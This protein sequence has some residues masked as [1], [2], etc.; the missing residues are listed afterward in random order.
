MHTATKQ[1]GS[2]R[3]PGELAEILAFL[4]DHEVPL[5]YSTHLLCNV[6]GIN[7]KQVADAAGVGRA[8][9]YMMLRDLRPVSA[10][11]RQAFMDCLGLDPWAPQGDEI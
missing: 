3:R 5:A 9:L 4:T 1:P 10:S 7:L 11:V 2:P 8:H 6:A